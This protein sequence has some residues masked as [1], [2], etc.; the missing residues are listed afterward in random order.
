MTASKGY[1]FEQCSAHTFITSLKLCRNKNETQK[2]HDSTHNTMLYTC[3]RHENSC[4]KKKT[5]PLN[6]IT[7][8][9]TT[10]LQLVSITNTHTQIEKILSSSHL[11]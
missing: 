7:A 5:N 11:I 1:V 4:N 8:N 2:M 6:C 9:T 3:N 10:T